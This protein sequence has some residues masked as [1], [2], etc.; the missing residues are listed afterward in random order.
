M[1]TEESYYFNHLKKAITHTFLKNNSASP[2]IETWKGE[3]ITA[4]QE[5]LFS[6]VKAKVSEKWFYTYFKN[7]PT[8]LPRIDMLNLLCNY[9]GDQNWNSFKLRHKRKPLIRSR[10]KNIK[11]FPNTIS[12]YT[13]YYRV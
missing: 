4:F 7:T 1:N 6:R 12:P 8:K 5:D 13:H 9:V 10:K 2:L 11:I 3:D